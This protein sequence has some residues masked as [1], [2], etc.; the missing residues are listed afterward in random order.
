[1]TSLLCCFWVV[2]AMITAILSTALSSAVNPAQQ[3]KS[4]KHH[5]VARVTLNNHTTLERLFK[6]TLSCS[7]NNGLPGFCDNT[8]YCCWKFIAGAD[9]TA[10]GGFCCQ[11]TPESGGGCCGNSCCPLGQYCAW[12][13]SYISIPYRIFLVLAGGF[14]KR[15]LERHY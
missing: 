13:D 4:D 2:T 14:C 6:R 8:A 10:N 1:M 3:P 15:L 9:N 12:A 5:D 7:F 11:N